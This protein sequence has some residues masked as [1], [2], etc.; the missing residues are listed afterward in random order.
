M[1]NTTNKQILPINKFIF[2]IFNLV[3]IGLFVYLLIGLLPTKSA[4]ETMRNDWYILKM[5]N[6]NMA[7]GKPTG[8]GGKV[9]FTMG[10]IGPGL[11]TGANYKVRAGFQ[12]I[13]T[14]YPFSF[15]ISQTS[16]DFGTI[17]PANPVIRTNILTVNNQSAGGYIVTSSENHP[18][19]V[20]SSGSMI[21][22]TTC[23]NGLCSPSS[24]TAWTSSLTYGFGY[25]CDNVSGTDCVTDFSTSTFYKPFSA[26]PSAT[27]VMNGVN[28]G[29]NKQS[30]ITY[31][32][33]VSATQPAGAYSN[34]VTYIA[35]PTF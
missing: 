1:T 8:A 34:L 26:S 29:K 11:Y 17:S 13:Y 22:N 19:L 14:L 10:Q 30:Q 3:L 28:A 16:I 18:M 23:D 24:A 32:V 33:N 15:T 35:T 25:R 12:Y 6:F 5:G 31:K 21:P 7:A 9:S 20:P 27:T 4:A 2:F